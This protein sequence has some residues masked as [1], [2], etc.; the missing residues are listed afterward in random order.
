MQ[1]RVQRSHPQPSEAL[2]FEPMLAPASHRPGGELQPQL[3]GRGQ[4]RLHRG[5][6]LLLL[7]LRFP[8]STGP[9]PELGQAL[10]VGLE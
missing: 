8:L 2:R 4:H 5:Q 7:D 10:L 6:G 9:L 1:D 3:G